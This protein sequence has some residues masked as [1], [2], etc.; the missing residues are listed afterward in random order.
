MF[1]SFAQLFPGQWRA[2]VLLLLAPL[3][4]LAQ[5]EPTIIMAVVGAHPAARLFMWVVLL[6][7][8]LLLAAGMWCTALS[9][10]TIPFRS[11]RGAFLTSLLMQWWD[12]G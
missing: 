6:V 12:A 8:V 2:G 10:Y 7:P 1:D 4:L 9:L 11:G 3:R 5:W